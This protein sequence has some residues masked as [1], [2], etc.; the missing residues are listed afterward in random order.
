VNHNGSLELAKK[1]VDVAAEAGAD[2]VKFQIFTAEKLVSAKAKKA[3]YQVKNMK[4]G[5]SNSQF[6][7]L[8]KLEL[9]EKDFSV[10][11]K[12]C[13]RKGV[14]FLA[15]AFDFDNLDYLF[16]LG[17]DFFKIPSGEITNLPYLKKVASYGLPVVLSTGMASLS[18]IEKAM[19]VLSDYGIKKQFITVL[20]CN[21]EYPT[22][23]RD[24][25]IKAMKSIGEAFRVKVGYSDH[26]EGITVPLVAAALGATI[27]EKHFTLDKSMKG[28]D[29]KAS[30][31]PSE[32]KAMVNS[33]RLL[34]QVMGDGVK[35]P[36]L[37]EAKNLAV[38][39]RSIHL[40]HDLKKGSVLREKDLEMLRP[41]DGISP[42]DLH[43]VVGK[44]VVKGL[45]KG[46]KLNFTD[47]RN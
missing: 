25:N 8:K 14:K 20:H 5:K 23:P 46:Y 37:S 38:A 43:L 28:P 17:V 10:L 3:S 32:L 6:E 12:Y 1:L 15:T 35:K 34:Q 27:I 19:D 36:S 30:L 45:K 9:T 24:V 39:R 22:P 16:A 41:G 31:E 13:T 11:K 4:G 18:D 2:Y 29:H 42:M 44:R 21:T 47:I 26:T 40:A 7:M 33:I